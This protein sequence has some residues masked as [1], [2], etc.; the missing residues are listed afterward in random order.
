MCVAGI[1]LSAS[2]K[3]KT[4]ICI[5]NNEKRFFKV[6]SDREIVEVVVENSAEVAAIDAP[7][8]LPPKST[9][10]RSCERKL[11]ELGFRPLSLLLP[12][13]RMLAIRARHVARELEEKGVK[14]IEVFADASKKVLGIAGKSDEVDAYACALTALKF[15]EG[16]YKNIDGIILPEK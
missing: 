9:P 12:S 14:V 8:W 1:D 7:L 15:R 3:K 13:M 2:P 16:K 4:C 5:L 6:S 10:W 11:I